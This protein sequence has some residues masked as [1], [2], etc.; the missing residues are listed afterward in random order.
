MSS[1]YNQSQNI[2]TL[3]YKLT[4]DAY[5][6]IQVLSIYVGFYD[7]IKTQLTSSVLISH[8]LY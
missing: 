2:S 6:R 3:E 8:A 4:K 1:K 5:E 7:S